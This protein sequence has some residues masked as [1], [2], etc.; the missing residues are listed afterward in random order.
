MEEPPE[1]VK[2][3][4][5]TTEI[6]KVPATI[7]SRCQRFDFK[8]ILPEDIS[9]RLKYIAEQEGLNLTDGAAYLIAKL[10][11]GGMRDAISLLDQASA[12]SNDITE[13]VVS[14]AVGIAGREYLF[15]ALECLFNRD[16]AKLFELVDSLYMQS[17]DLTVFCDSLISQL[18]NVMVIKVAPNQ[19]NSLACMPSEVE[20]L[21]KLAETLNLDTI[22]YYMESL[23]SCHQRLV[24][25][26]D[27][28][29]E[30]E[31]SIS[32]LCN[33]DGTRTQTANTSVVNPQLDNVVSNLVERID[34][35]ERRISS[36]KDSVQSS[37]Y[38]R[39]VGNRFQRQ[40]PVED[41]EF[42]KLKS[43]DFKQVNPQAWQSVLLELQRV[44]PGFLGTLD[45]SFAHV[46]GKYVLITSRNEMFTKLFR[47][48]DNAVLLGDI[49][50]RILGGKFVLKARNLPPNKQNTNNGNST[51]NLGS[52][53][54]GDLIAR[55][56]E[57]NIPTTQVG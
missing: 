47:F 33:Y 34:T 27:K 15:D 52:N 29:T 16:V 35:L 23:E 50:N 1:F 19:I 25:C 14:N 41:A 20:R 44:N 38:S 4:L 39:P 24:K 26:T 10:S 42:K 18:R 12:F 48:N 40:N 6:H 45:G 28:R 30:L 5:A 9:A 51:Q 17:K 55:A 53:S 2:F 3:I 49:V 36:L 13:E 37:N 7:L 31:V 22:L 11:D 21:T 8:R 56:K 43:E 46:C 57:N 32:G 54:F